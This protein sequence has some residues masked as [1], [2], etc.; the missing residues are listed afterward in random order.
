MDYIDFKTAKLTEQ[1][2]NLD[3]VQKEKIKKINESTPEE[4]LNE[5]RRLMNQ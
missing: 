3:E 5:F 1:I 2:D 4:M